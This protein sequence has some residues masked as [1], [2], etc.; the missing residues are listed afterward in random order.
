M[1]IKEFTKR[2][3]VSGYYIVTPRAENEETA[4]ALAWEASNAKWYAPEPYETRKECGYCGDVW[5]NEK[6][7]RVADIRELRAGEIG[8]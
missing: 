4:V 1:S 8:E 3:P 2:K 5:L 7:W 6:Q